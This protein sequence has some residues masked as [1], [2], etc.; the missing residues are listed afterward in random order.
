MLEYIDI[1][2]LAAV[3][4]L[5]TCLL[6]G[7]LYMVGAKRWSY[8]G[9]QLF[10]GSLFAIGLGLFCITEQDILPSFVAIIV[11]NLLVFSGFTLMNYSLRKLNGLSLHNIRLVVVVHLLYFSLLVFTTYVHPSITLRIILINSFLPLQYIFCA[12]H[13]FH[14]K[15]DHHT[16][17]ELL[18]S[19][20]F[21]SAATLF[22]V[23]GL[24]AF[25]QAEF[26]SFLNNAAGYDRFTFLCINFLMLIGTFG[27][28]WI[29]RNKYEQTFYAEERFDKLTKTYNRKTMHDLANL[30]M[31]RAQ[32]HN[33]ALS[34]ILADIDHFSGINNSFGPLVGDQVLKDL[35]SLLMSHVR[36]HDLI[37]RYGGEEF[38]AL[39]PE[40]ALSEA[41]M[42]AEKLR[43]TVAETPLG[44]K[45]RHH[46]TAS[47]GIIQMRSG[48]TWDV[49]M[50]RVEIALYQA[51]SMGRDCVVQG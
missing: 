42:V 46:I 23:R 41:L 39:L 30:E 8:P 29:I 47:F 21:I 26:T 19:L 51:K 7:C 27:F 16:A 49:L 31:K 50:H 13:F 9:L 32:R 2:T 35:G 24:L 33:V 5:H 14:R 18:I 48:E 40:T 43:K 38:L 44:S 3:C 22:V 37:F 6:G 1:R 12:Y 36:Q 28:L 34:L 4:F 11:S 10:A 17:L 25:S 20:L 45:N 15:S